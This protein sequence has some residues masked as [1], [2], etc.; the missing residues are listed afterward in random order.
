MNDLIELLAFHRWATQ[1]AWD[2][3]APISTDEYTKDLG[4][5]FSSVR[6]TLVHAFMADRAWL[7]RLEGLN[8]PRADPSE[9]PTFAV[10]QAAW[11]D[12][13]E[14]WPVVVQGIGDA[15][16]TIEYKTFAGDPY[17]N[18]LG[19][20]VRHVVNHGSYHRGQV[21]TLLRQQGLNAVS[22]DMIYFFRERH[23]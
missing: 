22:T 18:T 16:K 7:G 19:E 11:T 15:N 4:S 8:P 9:F 14:R 17:T 3:V 21:M 6:D 1:H 5:S 20:I 12:V 13:L 2:V 10:L 23:P